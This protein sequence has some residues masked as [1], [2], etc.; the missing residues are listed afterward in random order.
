MLVRG[1]TESDMTYHACL[2]PRDRPGQQGSRGA[3][4][5]RIGVGVGRGG[6]AEQV[7]EVDEVLLRGGALAELGAPPFADEAGGCHD[8]A[9]EEIVAQR[10]GGV[11]RARGIAVDGTGPRRCS[12]GAARECLADLVQTYQVS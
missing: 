10:R 7:T 9:H 2:A 6:N 1:D 12:N 8:G 4:S 3:G 5:A 11:N